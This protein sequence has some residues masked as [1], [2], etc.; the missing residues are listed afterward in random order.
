MS[1]ASAIATTPPPPYWA[2]IFTSLRTKVEAG[3]EQMAAA[4]VEL[5]ARQPGYLGIETARGT[6]GLGITVSYW[7][8]LEAIAVWK[9]VGDHLAAQSAGRSRWYSAFAV[10]IAQ[11][12]RVTSFENVAPGAAGPR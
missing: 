6:D 7:E 4:M 11:V 8:S 1:E 9:A 5:A 3:Y 12:A 2:V 10:R